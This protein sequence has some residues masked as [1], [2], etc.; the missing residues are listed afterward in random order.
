MEK[1][2][3]IETDPEIA[4][5]RELVKSNMETTFII[6][7]HMF[8]KVEKNMNM[9]TRDMEDRIKMSKMEILKF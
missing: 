2:Q 6:I 3:S 5:M 9:L 8:K 7:F 1:N 4:Q